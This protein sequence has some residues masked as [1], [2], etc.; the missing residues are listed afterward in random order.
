MRS[1][2]TSLLLLVQMAALAQFK[3]IAAGKSFQEPEDGFARIIQ[4]KNG[5]TVLAVIDLKK[6][7]DIKIYDEKHK[8]KIAKNI[9]PKF[10][11][12]KAGQ[13]EAMFEAKGNVVILVNE[14]QEKVPVLHRLVIDGL[15]GNIINE[16]TIGQLKKL[17]MGQGY[18]MAFGGVAPPDFYAQKDP[19]SDQYAVAMFNSFESDR[20][21]RVEL[22]MYDGDN[23]EIARAFYKSPE[24]K[25]KYINYMDM[26]FVGS[27]VYCL[28]YARNTRASGGKENTVIMAELKAGDTDV[29]LTELKFTH[30]QDLKKGMLRYNA[31]N[32]KIMLLAFAPYKNSNGQ[33]ELWLFHMD[34]LKLDTKKHDEISPMAIQK[35]ASEVFG[36]REKFTGTP[37]NMFVYKDG[38]YTVA[39]EEIRQV[40]HSSTPSSFGG[41]GNTGASTTYSRTYTIVEHLG[42]MHYDAGSKLVNSWYL[43]KDHYMWSAHP[44]TFYHRQREGRAVL[45]NDGDQ[46]KTF[47]LVRSKG[48]EYVLYNDVEE[49]DKRIEKGKDP[50][51][52]KGLKACDAFYFPLEKEMI[53]ARTFLFGEG[54]GRKDHRLALLPISD[55]NED[56]NIFVTLRLD[57]HQAKQVHLV[58]MEL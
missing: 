49:N 20:S 35:K 31:A 12:V 2:I 7:I 10:G 51:Q 27:T 38:S 22:V 30:D 41:T 18:A 16:E 58:W 33:G 8:Q 11:R 42:L 23:K 37:V 5:Y 47:T 1:F 19:N 21:K 53:P 28:G 9:R 48:K 39:L 32:N 44:P 56:Q 17:N 24:E 45:L 50:Q 14:V 54:E 55:F 29:K 4:M 13:V 36:R 25:Y 6:G 52:V 43:P 26:A 57:I 3:E 40:T 34:P 46:Y 15:K